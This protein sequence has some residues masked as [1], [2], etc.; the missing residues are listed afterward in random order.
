MNTKFILI[1]FLL[2]VIIQIYVPAKMIFAKEEVI[3]QGKEFRFKTAPVDPTDPFRGKYIILSFEENAFQ[4]TNADDW[5]P[6]DPVYVSLGTNASGFAQI[7]GV[8]REKPSSTEDYVLASIDY[9][10]NDS[11]RNMTIDYPFDRFY[12]EESKAANAELAYNESAGDTTQVT[13]ALVAVK[14]GDA[15]IKDV[16]INGVPIAEVAK[17]WQENNVE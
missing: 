4:V 10:F 6:G 14:N 15:V 9:I 7:L 2:M 17:N 13:Y 5:I 11:L 12:M 16:L 3:A 8:S 1:A